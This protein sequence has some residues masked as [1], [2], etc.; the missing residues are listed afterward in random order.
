MK[1]GATGGLGAMASSKAPP[2]QI[3]HLPGISVCALCESTSQRTSRNDRWNNQITVLSQ[4]LPGK[5][6]V[7]RAPS[8]L[9]G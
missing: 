6:D 9:R 5:L 4:F 1:F 7:R 8:P 2:L 3:M